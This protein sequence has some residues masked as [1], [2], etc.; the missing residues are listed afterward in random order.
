MPKSKKVMPKSN[1]TRCWWG[2]G[3]TVSLEYNW[4]SDRTVL[5]GAENGTHT[6][7]HNLA[8]KKINTNLLYNSILLLDT[9]PKEM[10]AEFTQTYVHKSYSEQFYS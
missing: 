6:F 10:K 4:N 2:W 3:A 9:S 5:V 7:V 8:L 1:N